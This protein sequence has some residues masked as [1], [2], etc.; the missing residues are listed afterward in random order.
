MAFDDR[1]EVAG[2]SPRLRGNHSTLGSVPYRDHGRS[3]PAPAGEP[4]QSES[5][6]NGSRSRVYPRACGGTAPVSS[7][8]IENLTVYPRACGG[9]FV[10]TNRILSCAS[11]GLSPR[12]RGNPLRRLAAITTTYGAGLSPRL[13]GNRR[14]ASAPN[15]HRRAVYPRAC[16]GTST[17]TLRWRKPPVEVYPRACGGTSRTLT[18]LDL[19]LARSIP[20]PAGEPATLSST[21]SRNTVYPRACGGTLYVKQPMY[22]D[23]G[24]SPRL[25]G[26]HQPQNSRCRRTLGRS[27]PAPAGEPCSPIV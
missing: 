10:P 26:N 22:S 27:I 13:R 16:G 12:L 24:L 7:G 15:Y 25:R 6:T 2:L 1:T 19:G 9:T 4:S 3:I 5:G 18:D 14:N 21:P 17:L 11:V 20:A 8:I 23:H